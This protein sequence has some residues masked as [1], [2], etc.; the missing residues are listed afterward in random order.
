MVFPCT[1]FLCVVNLDLALQET[2]III[3]FGHL[4]NKFLEH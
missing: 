4:P 3:F 2:L 1:S